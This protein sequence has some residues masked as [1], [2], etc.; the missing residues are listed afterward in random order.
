MRDSLHRACMHEGFGQDWNA[1]GSWQFEHG[2][3]TT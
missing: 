1:G 2:A 3:S